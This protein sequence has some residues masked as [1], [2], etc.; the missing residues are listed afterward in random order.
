M[1]A[2]VSLGYVRPVTSA[3]PDEARAENVVWYCKS[4]GSVQRRKAAESVWNQ[5]PVTSPGKL[6]FN[7]R[8]CKRDTAVFEKK[9][10]H[11][12]QH[13]NGVNA[14]T[15]YSALPGKKISF[16]LATATVNAETKRATCRH[17][18]LRLS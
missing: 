17:L 11:G 1:S 2:T 6:D 8:T 18:L 12:W 3:L 5:L 16:F 10:E 15:S 14:K 9:S 13:G 4:L 7:K